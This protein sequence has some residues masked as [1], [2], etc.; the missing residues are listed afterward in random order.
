MTVIPVVANSLEV[1]F[2]PGDSQFQ[3]LQRFLPYFPSQSFS[4]GKCS[5][6]KGAGIMRRLIGRTEIGAEALVVRLELQGSQI[7]NTPFSGVHIWSQGKQGLAC[8][9]N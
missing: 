4:R 2:P 3:A 6:V 1:T 5:K 7:K 9:M 8:E